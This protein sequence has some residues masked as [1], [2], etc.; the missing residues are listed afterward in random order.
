[1]SV[2]ATLHFTNRISRAVIAKLEKYFKK[3][4]FLLKNGYG[5]C[6]ITLDITVLA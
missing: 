1:M 2:A 5:E 4:S 6:A 3:E